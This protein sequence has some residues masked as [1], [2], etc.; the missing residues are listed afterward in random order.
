[1]SEGAFPVPAVSEGA[2]CLSRSHPLPSM[3]GLP[4]GLFLS[5][6]GSSE[7][8]ST[9]TPCSAAWAGKTCA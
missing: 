2:C 9:S 4:V 7:L 5:T 3:L 6:K 8:A 1:M